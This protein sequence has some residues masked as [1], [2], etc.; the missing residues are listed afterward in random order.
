M[1]LE[2][3]DNNDIEISFTKDA[4]YISLKIINNI[5]FTSR[6]IDIIACILGGRSYKKIASFLSI[7]PKT[8]EIHAR[9]IMAKLKCNSREGIIDF[10]EKSDKFTLIKNHYAN[11]LIKA[12]F[13]LELKKLFTATKNSINCLFF[14]YKTQRTKDFFVC[15][16][17]KHLNI[18]GIKTC[19]KI[20][21]KGKS[22]NFLINKLKNEQL[23]YIIYVM[24]N[25]FIEKLNAVEYEI[26]KEVSS[27]TP[28]MKNNSKQIIFFWLNNKTQEEFNEKLSGLVHIKLA[29]VGNYYFS[30]FDL[31]NKLLPNN[32]IAAYAAE[33]KKQYETFQE[34]LSLQKW[35]NENELKTATV[36]IE[37]LKH[38]QKKPPLKWASFFLLVICLGFFIFYANNEI[39]S[40][41]HK[42]QNIVVNSQNTLL[43]SQKE[44]LLFNIPP[45]NNNFTGRKKILKQIKKQL[46][47]QNFGVITQTI[48]GLGG[49]GKTQLATEFA[50][51]AAISNDYG[52]IL[53]INAETPNTINNA[54]GEFADQLEV[55]VRGLKPNEIQILIHQKLV[56]IYKNSK[57]LLVLD[58][59][60]C[61]NDTQDYLG[62]LSKQFPV[63]FPLHILIT[64]R[65]QYWPENPLMLDTFTPKEALMFIKKQLPDED[66]NSIV[67][68]T[69]TLYYFPLALNQASAYIKTH[70]NIND[71]IELYSTRQKD[72]LDKFSGDKNQYMESLWKTWDIAL[73]KLSGPA[74]E[75]LFIAS[76]LYPDEI[77]IRFFDNFT[78]EDR[79]NAI[80]DLRKHSFIILINN[81]QS[82][83]IHRLLQ[84][85]IRVTS[86][87][88]MKNNVTYKEKFYGLDKA[89]NL[90]KN[91]F[92]FHYTQ[93]DNWKLCR[94][95]LTHAQS[96]AEHAVNIKNEFL[97]PGVQLYAQVAMYLTYAQEDVKNAKQTWEKI[98]TLIKQNYGKDNSSTLALANIYT[99]LG[100]VMDIMGNTNQAKEYAEKAIVTYKAKTPDLSTHI[101]KLLTYLRW[102]LNSTSYDGIKFD[103]SFAFNILGIAEAHLANFETSKNYYEK[104]LEIFN[105]CKLINSAMI[106]KAALLQN[107]SGAYKD[108]G[109]IKQAR[110]ILNS[111]KIITDARQLKTDANYLERAFIYTR[112]AD[113]L[114]Y[115]GSNKA[116]ETLE[117]SLKIRL[118]M[119]SNE[120]YRIGLTKA[121]LGLILCT[122]NN[123]DEGLTNLKQAEMIYNK[124]FAKGHLRFMLLYVYMNY[125]F[126]MHKEYN[127]ALQYLSKAQQIA[128]KN[129]PGKP[130]NFLSHQFS[131]IEKFPS[132]AITEKNINYYTKALAL[133]KKI[134]GKNHIRA[135]RYHYLLGQV[136]ENRHNKAKAK[137]HYQAA[138]NIASKQRFNDETLTTGNQKNIYLIQEHLEKL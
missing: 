74:K 85:V 87:S 99:H 135:A 138:L 114:Y 98:V 28:I 33:F 111:A 49:V 107:L 97:H 11:L 6:E 44:T 136:F 108:C 120:H 16:L 75:I 62:K 96:L 30:I 52:A 133:I 104:A 39:K 130:Y 67:K 47:K 82:F 86:D 76:Y 59:V 84:E 20:W 126:E 80:E 69:K 57:V 26:T 128:T 116:K 112:L 66:E 91:K 124:N 23:D 53:W 1:N 60:P 40:I 68:L 109:D 102:E 131:P 50:Y 13:E 110:N 10:I 92:D 5:R 3:T 32:N 63:T 31:L 94:Q 18:A 56:G 46:N 14:Y 9:N 19:S 117:E 113:L 105:K 36:N 106:Y 8:V 7:S 12:T 115:I 88:D 45:R 71:Y 100:Y 2:Q 51:R 137:Q 79:G 121:K 81:N 103:Q 4:Y 132:L 15:E 17:E 125:A 122:E 22:E 119:Y 78:I 118:S 89:I 64:S 27:L 42:S 41:R 21:E 90:L 48:S 72:Y 95:Y 101:E 25:E 58:N 70:T 77:P 38:A 73:T 65:S 61:Y 83:K 35:Q 55:D 127:K 43:K 37:K 123:L 54:Y 24:T 34:P 134:F 93:V 129:F 29:K